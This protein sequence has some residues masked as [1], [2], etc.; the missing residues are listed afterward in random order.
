[1]GICVIGVG[2]RVIGVGIC[3]IL[4]IVLV[5]SGDWGGVGGPLL[6]HALFQ[7]KPTSGWAH[8]D[9]TGAIQHHGQ[10]E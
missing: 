4:S 5:L 8:G 6:R 10:G 9:I 1:M 3:M 2:I 7:F